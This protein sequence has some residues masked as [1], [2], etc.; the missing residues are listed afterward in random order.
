MKSR[1][2]HSSPTRL[3][4][5]SPGRLY[6]PPGEVL[7]RHP[8]AHAFAAIVISG[9]Y[10]E[11]GD[12]GRHCLEPGDVLLHRAW[13]SHTDVVDYNGAEVLIVAL[14]DAQVKFPLGRISNPDELVHLSQSQPGEVA[15]QLLNDLRPVAPRVT[16]WPDLLALALRENP[17]LSIKEWARQAGLHVGS[18]S[19]GFRQVFQVSPLFYRLVQRTHLA[20]AALRETDSPISLVAHNTGFADQAHMSRSIRQITQSTPTA[21]RHSRQER[22]N[23]DPPASA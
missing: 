5:A 9:G 13:E 14:Q 22:R 20:V 11:A 6:H 1:L 21:L 8:H 23:V 12:T 19:R 7:R 18:V 4:S 17:N 10:V 15:R 2:E 16:D 3:R